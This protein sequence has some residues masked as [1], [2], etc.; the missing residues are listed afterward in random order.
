LDGPACSRDSYTYGTHVVDTVGD[1]RCMA[2]VQPARGLSHAEV[3]VC[4]DAW[5]AAASGCQGVRHEAALETNP[6]S[7]PSPRTIVH[8]GGGASLRLGQHDV[9]K[10][11]GGGH[12]LDRLEVVLHLQRRRGNQ[13]CEW[14]DPTGAAS[15][16]C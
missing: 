9:D 14:V 11:L 5:V 13:T 6:R 15:P 4:T 3:L 16:F 10:V 12:R 2:V 8:D 7:H 1:E